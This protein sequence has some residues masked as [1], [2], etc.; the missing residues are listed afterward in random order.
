MTRLLT[1]V[2]YSA[3]VGA[4]AAALWVYV[5]RNK[6]N[7]SILLV[8]VCYAISLP[9]INSFGIYPLRYRMPI[10]LMRER[11]R[12]NFIRHNTN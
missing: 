9:R 5:C 8:V 11:E 2:C 4:A 1:L 6:L 12:E 3:A 7:N 10:L